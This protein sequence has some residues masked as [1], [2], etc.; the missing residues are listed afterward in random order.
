M[1]GSCQLAITPAEV[2]SLFPLQNPVKIGGI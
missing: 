1:G 2:K